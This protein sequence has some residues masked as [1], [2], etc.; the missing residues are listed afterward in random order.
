MADRDPLCWPRGTLHPQKVGTNFGDKRR[1]LRRYSSLTDSGHGV[2]LVSYDYARN[3]IGRSIG[4]CLC[5]R[6]FLRGSWRFGE[7]ELRCML[8]RLLYW[9]LWW[10]ISFLTVGIW[11]SFRIVSF[12]TYKGASVFICRVFDWKRSRISVRRRGEKYKNQNIQILW[13]LVLWGYAT[14]TLTFADGETLIYIMY[15][16]MGTESNVATKRNSWP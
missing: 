3:L 12:G 8:R 10:L 5:N 1:S 4:R 13:I 7:R 14:C 9:V 15:H 6:H 2:T 16:S 11:R